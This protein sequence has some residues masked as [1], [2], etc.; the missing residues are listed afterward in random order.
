MKGYI[1]SVI[2]ISVIGSLV[3]MLTPDGE[4]GG[5]SKNMRLVFGL[6][7]VLVCINPIKNI[8]FQLNDLTIDQILPP[9]N[10]SEEKYEEFFN[11]AYTSAEV[12]NL[13]EG[14]YKMLEDI[15]QIVRE[16]CEVSV[17]LSEKNGQ[18]SSD[19]GTEKRK[20]DTIYITLYGGA[21]FKN[22]DEIEEYLSAIFVCNVVTIIG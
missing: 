1:I 21:I 11:S 7:V 9:T 2:C 4:G 10:E 3:S 17:K 15:Y 13:K 12:E 16:D 6:C 20:L 8:I 14:I 18:E 22:T 5:I 19:L